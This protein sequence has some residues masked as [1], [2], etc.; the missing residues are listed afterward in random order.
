MKFCAYEGGPDTFGPNTVVAKKAASLDPRMSSLVIRYLN[1]WYAKGGDQFNWFV[2]G[3]S[4][5][6]TPY[7]TWALTDNLRELRQPKELAYDAVRIAPRAVLSTG[8]ALP[9]E[10]DARDFSGA[11]EPLANP[12]IRYIG[13]GSKF[14]YL[15]RVAQQGKYL[16]RVSISTDKPGTKLNILVNNS[17]V[18][19]IAVPSYD[20]NAPEDTFR[21]TAPVTLVFP[22][23]LSVIRLHVPTERPYNINSLKVTRSDGTGIIATQPMSPFGHA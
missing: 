2:L 10:I 15:V 19:T 18:Q 5:F 17:P 6:D 13:S 12:F 11:S 23:G 14:D 1:I 4:N 8:S 16:L 21:D 20:A 7:G 3:A 22:A 9:S